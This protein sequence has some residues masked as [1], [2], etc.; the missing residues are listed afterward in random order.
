MIELKT[1][2]GLHLRG[3]PGTDCDSVLAQPKRLA[4]LVYLAVAH[5]GEHLRRDTLLA[6]F[7]PELDDAH[8]RGALRQSVRFLRRALGAQVLIA[9]GAGDLSVGREA[10]WCDAVAF[11]AAYDAGDLNAAADLYQGDLLDGLYVSDA[12]PDLERWIEDER[13]HIRRRAAKALWHVV[14]ECGA[15]GNTEL[16]AEHARRALSLF[17]EDESGLCRLMALLGQ[18]EDRE[19]ATRAYETFA[20]HLRAEYDLLPAAET[21]AL[22]AAVRSRGHDAMSSGGHLIADPSGVDGAADAGARRLVRTAAAVQP[23]TAPAKPSPTFIHVPSHPRLRRTVRPIAAGVTVACAAMI[24]VA[25]SHRDRALQSNVIAVA[26]WRVS[27]ADS[28]LGYLAEGMVD[29]LGTTLTG[30]GGPRAV[31][32]RTVLAAWH[33]ATASGDAE[34]GQTEALHIARRLGADHLLLGEV[35][36]S[37]ARMVMNATLLSVA[38]GAVRVRTVAAGPSDSLTAIVDELTARLLVLHAREGAH[39]VTSAT[40]ASLPALRAYLDGQAAYRHGRYRDAVENFSLAL[41]RDSTFALAGWGIASAAGWVES[42]SAGALASD[43][44]RGLKVALGWQ[45][46]LSARDRALIR[47]EAGRRY[48]EPMWVGDCVEEWG[49]AVTLAPDQP[50]A[51]FWFGD[52]FYHAGA[53]LPIGTAR[54]RA[55]DAFARSLKLD[56]TVAGSLAHL[57]EM[58]ARDGDR[59]AVRQLGT[60]YLARDSSADAAAYMRWRM[61]V[62]LDDKG[63][64]NTLRRGFERASVSS[65]LH[66]LVIMQMDGVGLGDA[67]DAAAALRHRSNAPEDRLS[68]ASVLWDLALTRGRPRA[69]LVAGR[70]WRAAG[71]AGSDY[72]E[73]TIGQ[74]LFAD[75]DRE[76]AQAALRALVDRSD[77]RANNAQTG[78]AEIQSALCARSLWD[79]L[80]GQ[81]AA[82]RAAIGTLRMPAMPHD[83]NGVVGKSAMCAATLE[84][85]LTATTKSPEAASALWR[86]DS[87]ASRGALSFPVTWLGAENLVIARLLEARG[88]VPRALAAVRRRVYGGLYP[89]TFLAPS[90]RE[91]GRLAALS[92]DREGAIRAYRHYLALRASPELAHQADVQHIRDRLT[93][94]EGERP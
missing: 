2:G 65:L 94:L 63:V 59:A 70:A 7:W 49:R 25:S 31:D 57:V 4:L 91:E 33:R 15:S 71:G 37:P 89:T 8:A 76:A 82:T 81:T 92:G 66:M 3:P 42:G 61:A 27:G 54:S 6:L 79:V 12:A 52:C 39:R 86:L 13:A 10:L 72:L 30:E 9:H 44:H 84:A 41:D 85:L 62:A 68:V 14:D 5:R 64:L 75:G 53:L 69:A 34:P 78:G 17:P 21:T 23:R 60:L 29:L 26:P 93:A 80:H 46:R 45:H 48:P 56:S 19:G 74:A 22:L 77:P 20:R 83:T 67:D 16:A 58:A 1:L 55:A 32:P 87:L 43:E 73:R 88:D 18:L 50:E 51:W 36:G 38:S 24:V 40:S 35:V 11:E 28:S 90:L 47:A